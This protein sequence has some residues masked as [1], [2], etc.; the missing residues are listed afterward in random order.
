M[1]YC[2][3]HFSR[4]KN[5]KKTEM[6]QFWCSLLT[7][8]EGNILKK[9]EISAFLVP[10]LIIKEQQKSEKTWNF[11]ILCFLLLSKESWI[12][13]ILKFQFFWVAFIFS[14]SKNKIEISDFW[15]SRFFLK[16]QSHFFK[17]KKKLKFQIFCSPSYYKEKNE[18]L[19]NSEFQNFL[20]PFVL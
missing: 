8:A 3:Y 9:Y 7:W 15:V 1:L 18:I 4:T 19:K 6:S 11:I 5:Q 12:P 17:K 14:K 13:K 2:L 10:L 20:F 16:K